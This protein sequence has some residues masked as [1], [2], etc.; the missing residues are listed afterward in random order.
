[1]STQIYKGK[2]YDL[3]N[4]GTCEDYLARYED[5]QHHLGREH[6]IDEARKELHAS[7]AS[8]GVFISKIGDTP[9]VRKKRSGC[10]SRQAP[11][12]GQETGYRRIRRCSES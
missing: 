10:E 6:A 2:E 11:P 1:M 9:R 4:L 3:T 5:E 12:G 7:I 8:I